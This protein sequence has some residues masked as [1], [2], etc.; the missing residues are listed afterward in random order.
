MLNE[1]VIEAVKDGKFHIYAV[2][3][4]EEGIEILT[5]VK[6]GKKNKKGKYPEDTIHCLVDKKLHEYSESLKN[7][8]NNKKT[9]IKD[10]K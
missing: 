4:I 8:N 9:K 10:K 3:T 2:G 6:A 1:E 5:G 7:I